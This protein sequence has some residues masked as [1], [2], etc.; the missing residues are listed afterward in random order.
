MFAGTKSDRPFE[1]LAAHAG[2]NQAYFKNYVRD[3]KSVSASAK[4]EAHPHYT[5]GQL[6]ALMAFITAEPK[7][8]R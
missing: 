1:V 7:K 6:D 2:Y 8:G 3:P 4:M 5:D